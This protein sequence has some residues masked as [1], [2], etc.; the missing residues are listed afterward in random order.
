MIDEA[1]IREMVRRVVL[2]TVEAATLGE[3]GRKGRLVTQADVEEVPRGGT[4][5]AP[6]GAIVTPLARQAALDRRVSI[7]RGRGRARHRLPR[8]WR[9][10]GPARWPSPPTTGVSS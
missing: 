8:S 9:E 2:R 1:R 5:E 4:M 6:E 3:G 10:A 7:R